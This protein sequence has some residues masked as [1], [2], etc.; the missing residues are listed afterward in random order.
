MSGFKVIE[1]KGGRL[2]PSSDAR[3]KGKSIRVNRLMF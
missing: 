2:E 3:R 1:G